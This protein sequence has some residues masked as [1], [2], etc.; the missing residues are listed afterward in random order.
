M[1]ITFRNIAAAALLSVTFSASAALA[2]GVSARIEGPAKSGEYTVR[3]Y[4]C[5]NP[6]AL[7]VTVWAEGVVD[8]KRQT[9]PVVVLKTKT[10]GVYQFT[11]TWPE[12]GQWAIRMALAGAGHSPVTLTSLG[13]KGSVKANC[14]IWDGDGQ[15]ELAAILAGDDGC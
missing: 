1:P 4:Q 9:V 11:R 8:G 5:S 10:K 3:T 7:K 13:E 12:N 15:R 6:A 2:G 14:L